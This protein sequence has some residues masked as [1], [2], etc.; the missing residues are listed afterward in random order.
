MAIAVNASK[1]SLS[2]HYGVLDSAI[3]VSAAVYA[4]AVKRL[5][6]A[7]VGEFLILR[8]RTITTTHGQIGSIYKYGDTNYQF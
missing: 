5:H 4:L 1:K 6:E 3:G 2:M 7:Q 8:R